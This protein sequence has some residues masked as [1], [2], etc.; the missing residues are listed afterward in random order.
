V[1][2]AAGARFE[3]S[4]FHVIETAQQI[5]YIKALPG[6]MG[7]DLKPDAQGHGSFVQGVLSKTAARGNMAMLT[8]YL[9]LPSAKNP[10]G[11]RL[12][13]CNNKVV[14][15]PE[16]YPMVIKGP[17]GYEPC[18]LKYSY[19]PTPWRDRDM[20][21]VEHLIDPQR[22][23][24]DG[25]NK[26]LE[27][28][29]LALNPQILAPVGAFTKKFRPTTEPGAVI[30]YNPVGGK[31]PEWQQPPAPPQFLLEMVQN[32]VGDMDE[33]ASLYQVPANL[34]SSRALNAYLGKVQ[35]VEA[36]IVNALADFYGRLGRHLLLYVQENY[37]EA[38]LLP[39]QGRHGL[40]F[41]DD[42]KG[43]DLRD[44]TAVNVQPQSI[45]PQTKEQ[46]EQTV[47]NF[48]QLGWVDKN[49]AIQAIES[50]TTENLVE[51]VELDEAKQWRE[52]QD[53][54]GTRS[55][56]TPGG[57]IPQVVPWDND[58]VHMYVLKNWLQTVEYE[59]EPDWVK[60]GAVN[61]Y[62]A[63]KLQMETKQMQQVQQQSALAQ[64]MGNQNAARP[65][66]PSPTP[67]LASLPQSHQ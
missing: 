37:T 11:R 18:I 28:M 59:A 25:V 22:T 24:N 45:T 14:C 30:Y 64:S 62:N 21:L 36:F 27:W 49:Q 52:I 57:G 34:S 65:S 32:A 31:P 5:E 39:I 38:R 29:K 17:G 51:D 60:A 7:G 61:H 23:V 66:S 6:Y 9:E 8:E 4:P 43:A 12:F 33:I 44:Q 46:V 58:A 19:I 56:E 26:A 48:A 53:M 13:I 2:W 55:E 3:E 41:I 10:E 20:G 63:H 35:A 16:P 40:D 15:P 47:M 67:S 42:F 50:G 1:F 54:M